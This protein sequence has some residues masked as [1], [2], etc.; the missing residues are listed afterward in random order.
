MSTDI[1]FQ[2][3]SIGLTMTLKYVQLEDLTPWSGN[4]RQNDHVVDRVVSSIKKF[5]F[6]APIVANKDGTII[7]GHT[8]YKAAQHMKLEKV[9]VHFLDLTAEEAEKLALA[10][11]KLNELADWNDRE[12][13]EILKDIETEEAY[14]LGWNQKELI[15]LFDQFTPII[16]GP[17]EEDVERAAEDEITEHDSIP[18]DVE[19]TTKAGDVVDLGNHLLCCADNLEIMRRLPSNSI[20]CIVTD[21]PYGIDFMQKS[22]DADVPQNEWAR[23]CLRVLKSGGYLISFAATRTFHKLVTNL[24]NAGFEV[25]D[26]IN[27]L[28]FSGFPKSLDVSKAIDK[29]FGAEREIVG[30]QKLGGTAKPSKGINK[31][32]IGHKVASA[33]ENYERE[34]EAFHNITKP[35]TEEAQQAEGI[36]TALKPAFEPAT[37]C[38]KPLSEKTVALNWL[39]YKTGGINIDDC[40][41]AYGDPCWVGPQEVQKQKDPILNKAFGHKNDGSNRMQKNTSKYLISNVSNLGRWPANI[42]QCPKASRS[43]REKGLDDMKTITGHEAVNRKEGSAGLNNPRAGAGR[44]ASEVANIHPTVKPVKLMRWLVRLVTPKNGIVLEPFCGSGTTMIAAELEDRFCLG[45]EREPK[46][47]DIIKAR[48]EHAIHSSSHERHNQEFEELKK[49]FSKK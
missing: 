15:E 24:E 5:G 29:H 34:E 41:F 43:E 48:A 38:R 26:T 42:Y 25:R 23:E 4:P 6:A 1:S 19:P 10:D 11:N 33:I 37:L 22:W 3:S 45:I 17:E 2:H 8:R 44:T 31:G 30:K 49:I 47:C 7:A 18:D 32:S 12:L 21:P 39:K 36:G 28:Y 40:R 14:D 27:W 9:P 16:D 46:Y 20:D 35:A 13:Y